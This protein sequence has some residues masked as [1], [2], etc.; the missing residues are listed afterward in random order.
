MP[1]ERLIMKSQEVVETCSLFNDVDTSSL[2]GTPDEN[3]T[4]EIKTDSNHSNPE[5]SDA[6]E[7][8]PIQTV[9]EY[10]QAVESNQEFLHEEIPDVSPEYYE[11][12]E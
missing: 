6:K 1:I 12:E 9:S 7:P 11:N 4:N 3:D 8:E 10:K 2:S 5:A